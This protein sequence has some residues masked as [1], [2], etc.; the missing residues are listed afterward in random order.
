MNF[1]SFS[2]LL[3]FWSSGWCTTFA[4]D[5]TGDPKAEGDPYCTLFVGCLSE[6]TDERSLAEVCIFYYFLLLLLCKSCNCCQSRILWTYWLF[7]SYGLMR[8]PRSLPFFWLMKCM[9]VMSKYGRVKRLRLV[10]HIGQ[11][12]FIHIKKSNMMIKC[13]LEILALQNHSS[14]LMPAFRLMNI[15]KQVYKHG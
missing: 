3:G 10:R 6:N 14:N 7:S 8:D 9:Q 4:D 2:Q 12:P 15:S 5:A 11:F 1:L 13:R